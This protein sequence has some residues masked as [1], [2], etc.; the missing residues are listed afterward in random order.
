MNGQGMDK[1]VVL[2]SLCVFVWLLQAGL[3]VVFTEAGY[4]E[5]EM[6]WAHSLLLGSAVAAGSFALYLAITL[7]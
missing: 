1:E 6:K 2:A 3:I 7:P 5:R 4:H